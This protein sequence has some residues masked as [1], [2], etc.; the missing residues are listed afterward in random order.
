MTDGDSV[1]S[2]IDPHDG[3]NEAELPV[4]PPAPPLPPPPP[5][6]QH[7]DLCAKVAAL[8]AKIKKLEERDHA[9]A[10]AV[11]GYKAEA[12]AAQLRAAELERGI[13]G[14]KKTI[15]DSGRDSRA[16]QD[17]NG[18]AIRELKEELHSQR[19]RV[20]SLDKIFQNPDLSGLNSLSL[21]V[22]LLE[23]RLKNLEAGLVN[24]LKERFLTLDAGFGE[25]ARKAGL[26]QETA[27]AGA[28]RVEK[29][30]ERVV[31]LPY[32]ENRLKSCEDKLEA[33]LANELK[34]RFSTLDAAFG[35]TARKAGL[36]QE[37]AAGGA[38]RVEK[39]EERVARLPYLENR[40]KSSEDKLE[41]IYDLEALTQSL[42]LSV[43]GMEKSFSA[44]MRESSLVSAEHKKIC[45]DFESL[46]R[47]VKQ[48]TAL[49]N[50]FR[51]ELAFLMP[52]KQ[53]SSGR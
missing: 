40:L 44:A 39:L 51:T 2:C 11:E 41:R 24:E 9:A 37:I 16:G 15:E 19:A 42:N 43:E 27:A 5:P 31:R 13:S 34:E 28:R 12:Q 49:F 1:F 21:S 53:E 36:A 10:A 29:L 7:E 26:A 18:I 32:L 14:L 20:G 33:G 4:P 50:Q 48:L 3:R 52:R 38:R 35:E 25:T 6:G 47:Q 45:S 30:E 46:S 22:G 8:E 23:G 17:T